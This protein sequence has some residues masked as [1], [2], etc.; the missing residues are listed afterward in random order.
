MNLHGNWPIRSSITMVG[1]LVRSPLS[2]DY[3]EQAT[4]AAGMIIVMLNTLAGLGKKKKA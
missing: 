2:K 3:N 1:D 4:R